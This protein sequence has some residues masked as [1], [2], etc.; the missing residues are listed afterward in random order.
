MYFRCANIFCYKSCFLLI[1]TSWILSCL[2]LSSL[3][4]VLAS[5]NVYLFQFL[6]N[7][8]ELFLWHVPKY[9]L[10]HAE[11]NKKKKKKKEKKKKQLDKYFYEKL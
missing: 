4:Y 8:I 7:A 9:K 11:N 10:P 6:T 5:I 2:G 1:T 3:I